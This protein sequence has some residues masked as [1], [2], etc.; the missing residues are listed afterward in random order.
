M[1]KPGMAG[2]AGMAGFSPGTVSAVGDLADEAQHGHSYLRE[3]VFGV[4]E[5][6]PVIL[7]LDGISDFNALHSGKHNDEVQLYAF[8][9]LARS[10]Q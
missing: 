4:D 1:P 6:H 5:I 3:A 10:H 7:G 8:D 2:Q 9:V